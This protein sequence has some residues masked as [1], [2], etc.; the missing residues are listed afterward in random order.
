MYDK[1]QNDVS[2]MI[3]SITIEDDVTD[4]AGNGN[5]SS[6]RASKSGRSPMEARMLNQFV[7]AKPLVCGERQAG[8]IGSPTGRCSS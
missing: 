7:C 3:D 4:V 2:A 8:G 5:G 1:V 6:K